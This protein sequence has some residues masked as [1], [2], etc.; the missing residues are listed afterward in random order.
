MSAG[1]NLI[2][3][4]LASFETGIP[5]SADPIEREGMARARQRIRGDAKERRKVMPVVIHPLSRHCGSNC[6]EFGRERPIA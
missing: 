1:A 4:L 3:N 5:E 6:S 2:L